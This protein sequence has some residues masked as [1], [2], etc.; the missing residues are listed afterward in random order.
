MLGGLVMAGYL[1]HG[2]A[3]TR[4]SSTAMNPGWPCTDTA[5]N[6]TYHRGREKERCG[7]RKRREWNHILHHLWE[8]LLLTATPVCVFVRVWEISISHYRE[9]PNRT[10][11]EML[12]LHTFQHG[13]SNYV[14]CVNRPAQYR[15]ACLSS[16]WLSVKR[17]R[18]SWTAASFHRYSTVFY[19]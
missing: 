10:G 4:T 1:R 17:I 7:E 3:N 12:F 6:I 5:S 11:S 16:V 13:S 2:W 18:E 9:K 8:E 14:V 15:L 19:S